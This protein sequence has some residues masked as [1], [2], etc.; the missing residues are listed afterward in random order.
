MAGPG[1]RLIPESPGKQEAPEVRFLAV[2]AWQGEPDLTGWRDSDHAE[3]TEFLL[4]SARAI[5]EPSAGGPN[6]AGVRILAAPGLLA[7]LFRDGIG[8]LV[9]EAG[10]PPEPLWSHLRDQG[11]ARGQATRALDELFP[12]GRW[13]WSIYGPR[14]LTWTLHPMRG[15]PLPLLYA[16]TQHRDPHSPQRM[17]EPALRRL[18]RRQAFD[19]WTNWI[20]FY[21]RDNA[22]IL[23]DPDG[24]VEALLRLQRGDLFRMYLLCLFLKV[25]LIAFLGDLAGLPPTQHHTLEEESA[26]LGRIYEQHYRQ[27]LDF[28]T[29]DWFAEVSRHTTGRAVYRVMRRALGLRL[30]LREVRSE[31]RLLRQAWS[32]RRRELERGRD[33][34]HRDRAEADSKRLSLITTYALPFLAATGAMGMNLPFLGTT[35]ED[36]YA[37]WIWFFV[38]FAVTWGLI[39]WQ[40]KPARTTTRSAAGRS[41]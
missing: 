14:L 29:N 16:L 22:A 24:E 38:F 36:H 30:L 6:A 26:E 28:Q 7:Y 5:F 9:I 37:R 35:G 12:Q 41:R 39:Q 33:R 20:A 23:V 15:D 18:V 13:R 31:I 8:I 32:T 27:Y 25:R 11:A 40:L 2:F 3:V 4:D 21:H 17:R 1:G 34:R 10:S 19:T